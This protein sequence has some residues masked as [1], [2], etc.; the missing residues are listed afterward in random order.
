MVATVRWLALVVSLGP[1]L[2]L[3][4][5]EIT[6]PMGRKIRDGEVRLEALS[7]PREDRTT[8]WFGTGFGQA[9]EVEASLTQTAR[10]QW[11]ASLDLSYNFVP[12][13]TD[14]APGISVGVSDLMNRTPERRSFYLATTYRYGNFG[15]Q[16]QDVPTE[17]TFGFWTRP[18]GAV[19]FGASFPFTDRVL[20]IAEHNSVRI[21]GGIELRPTRWATAKVVFEPGATL[22]SLALSRRF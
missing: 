11:R 3:A 8:V 16:N 20:L 13:L 21:A 17:F 6:V 14:I 12:P 15:T 5:R 2:A 7:L 22:Y 10:R 9:Y 18:A 1:A 19:F 4:D